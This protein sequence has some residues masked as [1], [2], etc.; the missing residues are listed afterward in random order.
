MYTF[1]EKWITIIYYEDIIYA[2]SWFRTDGADVIPDVY[3]YSRWLV[4]GW[5]INLQNEHTRRVSYSYN[6]Q[7]ARI[8]MYVIT[9]IKKHIRNNRDTK[10]LNLFFSHWQQP[11]E[12]QLGCDAT[13]RMKK[14]RLKA[15]GSM[16]SSG[17]HLPEQ[18]RRKQ[19]RERRHDQRR[20][21]R[22][23]SDLIRSTQNKYPHL[24]HHQ[25]VVASV[26]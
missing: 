11:V 3:L 5:L 20:K 13:Q 25:S 17:Q 1:V 12:M 6:V 22:K 2:Y 24:Q 19:I 14:M 16:R 9:Y 4:N 21:V 10:G 8:V 23:Q 7:D 18:I 15:E 26:S